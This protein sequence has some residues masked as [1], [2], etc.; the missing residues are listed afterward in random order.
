MP[1]SAYL[2]TASLNYMMLIL[3][4]NK[5]EPFSNFFY[6]SYNTTFFTFL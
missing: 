4:R 2:F 1:S 5:I 3:E 6:N